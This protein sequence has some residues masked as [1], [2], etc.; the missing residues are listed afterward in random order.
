M[1]LIR[2]LKTANV[3][4]S[5]TWYVDETPTDTSTPPLVTV[6]RLDGTVVTGPTAASGPIGGTG[7]GTYTYTLPG[8]PTVGVSATYQLDHLDVA[9]VGTISG[10]AVTL[11]DRVEVVGGFLFGLAEARAADSSLANRT[12]YPT[13]ALARARMDTE[14]EC[15]RICRQA[16]VPRFRRL[17][18]DGTGTGELPLPDPNVRNPIRF[19]SAAY[20]Y[21]QAQVAFSVAQMAFVNADEASFLRRSDGNIWP[22]GTQNVIVEYEYGPDYPPP[23]LA[24]AAMLRFRSLLNRNRSGIPDR[25]E[26]IVNTDTGTSY[27]LSMPSEDRTGI[28]EVDAAY[29]RA[30]RGQLPGLA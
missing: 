8:G 3:T 20:W 17:T 12:T 18:L 23:E 26:R 30:S 2:V 29:A 13:T 1:A 4:L 28:P 19:V 25:A 22:L 21:G 11:V 7:T 5:R 10:V 9:W 16:F 14:R 15:E 6:R 27:L 24:D